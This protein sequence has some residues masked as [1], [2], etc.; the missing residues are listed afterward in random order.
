MNRY[1]VMWQSHSGTWL[2][3]EIGDYPDEYQIQWFDSMDDAIE[4]AN[5][6]LNVGD[7]FK[8]FSTE[9]DGAEFTVK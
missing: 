7:K 9:F 3:F 5:K 6:D 8:V 2:P 1:F 4:Q